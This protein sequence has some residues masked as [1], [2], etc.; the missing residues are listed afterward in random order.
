MPMMKSSPEHAV[1]CLSKLA[2]A[3][4]KTWKTDAETRAAYAIFADKLVNFEPEVVTRA[5]DEWGGTHDRWPSLASL[6]RLC[7]DYVEIDKTAVV[8]AAPKDLEPDIRNEAILLL[9]SFDYESRTYLEAPSEAHKQFI[10]EAGRMWDKVRPE[11]GLVTVDQEGH[12]SRYGFALEA[13]A[14]AYL[15]YPPLHM[16]CSRLPLVNEI[17]TLMTGKQMQVL[18]EACNDL[19]QVNPSIWV[20]A[21]NWLNGIGPKPSPIPER[22]EPEKR[23]PFFKRATDEEVRE[24]ARR[25]NRLLGP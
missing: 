6:L 24:S 4:S 13:W 10:G 5:C 20:Q 16:A 1:A 19:A 22:P 12:R 25:L 14:R 15:G 3:T 9:G 2:I 8:L 17:Y 7:R 11:G 23:P 21:V 18:P